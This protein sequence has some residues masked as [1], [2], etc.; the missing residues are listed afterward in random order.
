MK[1]FLVIVIAIL[2]SIVFMTPAFAQ[3]A[4]PGKATPAKKA[5]PMDGMAE[6]DKAAPEKND[7]KPKKEEDKKPASYSTKP[8]AL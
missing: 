8:A 4:A 2:V 6:I 3:M 5:A 1:K 7:E